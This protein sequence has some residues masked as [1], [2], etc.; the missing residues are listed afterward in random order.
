MFVG[1][2]IDEVG[3]IYNGFIAYIFVFL[4]TLFNDLPLLLGISNRT[5]IL[6]MYVTDAIGGNNCYD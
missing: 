1:K 6:N 4:I 2:E 5:R 3:E